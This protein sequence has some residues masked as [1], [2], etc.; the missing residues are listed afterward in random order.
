MVSQYTA[1]VE[2]LFEA[3]H[4]L[5]QSAK[6]R[7]VDAEQ[8]VTGGLASVIQQTGDVLHISDVRINAL[9]ISL[10]SYT[11]LLTY[12]YIVVIHRSNPPAR[13]STK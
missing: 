2:P 9:S 11:A 7:I 8:R 13:S 10:H 12:L 3:L 5:L 1:S 4:I 6:E